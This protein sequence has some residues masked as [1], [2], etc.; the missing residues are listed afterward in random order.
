[1]RGRSVV[2]R[3]G[4]Q[5]DL[6]GQ[7]A[8]CAG[9]DPAGRRSA[10]PAASGRDDAD[11]AVVVGDGDLVVDRET[12][13]WGTVHVDRR[14]RDAAELE[15]H[16]ERAHRDGFPARDDVP[17]HVMVA[18]RTREPD[19]P[20]DMRTV[21]DG[22]EDRG[23]EVHVVLHHTQADGPRRATPGSVGAPVAEQIP[24]LEPAIGEVDGAEGV[25]GVQPGAPDTIRA[26]A[27][28]EFTAHRRRSCG[29]KLPDHVCGRVRAEDRGV[30]EAEG[31]R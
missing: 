26:A 20:Q 12:V 18:S 25:L 30:D 10:V 15:Q 17:V 14:V 21:L 5:V 24:A 2:V 1:M 3:G 13:A 29:D 9:G 16:P 19:V 6:D 8:V 22:G 7:Y 27:A 31:G 4:E 11:C 23:H 28:E